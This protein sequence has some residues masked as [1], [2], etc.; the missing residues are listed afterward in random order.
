MDQ[1]MSISIALSMLSYLAPHMTTFMYP[2]PI[3]VYQFRPQPPYIGLLY[4]DQHYLILF[5][6]LPL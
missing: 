3:L 4:N 1:V 5:P 2:L 6:P